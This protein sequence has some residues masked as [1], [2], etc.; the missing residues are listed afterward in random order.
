M[1]AVGSHPPSS[2]LVEL[3]AATLERGLD[4]GTTPSVWALCCVCFLET[5]GGDYRRLSDN[6]GNDEGA[7]DW[8]E[9]Q[10]FVWTSGEFEEAAGCLR[11]CADS[12]DTCAGSRS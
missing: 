8:K 2:E 5:P 6:Q 4:D 12:G 1:A 3:D 9:F 10:Q 11:Y 7:E